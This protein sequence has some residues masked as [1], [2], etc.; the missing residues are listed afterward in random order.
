MSK[1][2]DL[3]HYSIINTVF[4]LLSLC[5]IIAFWENF[6]RRDKVLMSSIVF[7][8]L[9]A[10][11]N[12]S[13]K[14]ENNLPLSIIFRKGSSIIGKRLD[15]IGKI[16]DKNRWTERIE[17][18]AD[19][20]LFPCFWGIVFINDYSYTSEKMRLPNILLFDWNGEPLAQLN[21]NNHITAFNIDFIN[22]YLYT[23]DRRTDIFCKYDIR[24]IP[25]KL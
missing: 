12:F 7:L 21:L 20:R 22:G 11:P 3:R 17:T 15:H 25:G 23:L 24:E 1:S 4:G 19:L 10:M 14:K 18:F 5:L 9:E 13:K 8:L 2:H 6:L 16:Q